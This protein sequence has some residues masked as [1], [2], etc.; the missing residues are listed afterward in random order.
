MKRLL[1]VGLGFVF[2]QLLLNPAP[3]PAAGGNE[4]AL[5]TSSIWLSTTYRW[6]T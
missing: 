4:D 3:G 2:V 6:K 5:P 1:A